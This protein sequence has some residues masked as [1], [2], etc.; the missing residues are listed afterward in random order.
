MASASSDV[1]DRALAAYLGLAIGDALGA[2]VEFMTKEEIARA[3]GVH[4]TICGGGWLRLRPGQVTDDTQM[5]LAL[6]RSL[7]RRGTCDLADICAE[8]ARWLKAGPID[9][10]NTCRRGIS[11]Y[12]VQGTLEAPASAGDAGNGAAMRVLPVALATLGRPERVTDWT[13]GQSHITHH[14][15]LSDAAA[16]AFVEMTQALVSGADQTRLRAYAE[17][18]QEK[19]PA[20]R[21]NPYPGLS[22]GYVVETLQTVLH[23]YFATR[24]FT[25]CLIATVNQGGDAD[26]TGALAGMLAGA[27]YGTSAIPRAWLDR[28]DRKVAAEIKAQVPKLLALAAA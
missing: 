6:G 7:I 20:L 22:S 21:F 15:P 3:Y 1:F 17:T 5:A 18:L 28:L 2:T 24:S 23:Y 11:R 9:V 4:R 19:V 12:I 14:H 27:S 26:T 13:I 10:G 25:D 8:F 16:L